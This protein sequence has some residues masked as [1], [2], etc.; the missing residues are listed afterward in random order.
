[1]KFTALKLYA[2]KNNVPITKDETIEFIVNYINQNN[3]CKFHQIH[4]L[5]FLYQW[6]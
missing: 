3:V 1:M 5:F 2:G 4:I 6:L